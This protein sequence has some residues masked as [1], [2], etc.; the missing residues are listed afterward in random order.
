MAKVQAIWLVLTLAACGEM[1]AEETA[2]MSALVACA[3]KAG[4]VFPEVNNMPDLP[5]AEESEAGEINVAP[6]GD[7]VFSVQAVRS[8]IAFACAGNI[9]RKQ[10]DLIEFGDQT[11]R[12]LEGQ[13][14][15][16]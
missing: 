2:K 16:Y 7:F 8:K 12:P 3:E 10:I 13:S 1:T 5:E 4:A 9:N 15:S 11:K 14:W 6:N